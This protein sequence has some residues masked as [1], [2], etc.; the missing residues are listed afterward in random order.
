[1]L[2]RKHKTEHRFPYP[3]ETRIVNGNHVFGE[4]TNEGPMVGLDNKVG[5]SKKVVAASLDGPGYCSGFQLDD[6]VSGV[7][8]ASLGPNQRG[9]RLPRCTS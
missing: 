4:E 5:T 7:G 6:R 2:N 3:D 9:T 1:M 8:V